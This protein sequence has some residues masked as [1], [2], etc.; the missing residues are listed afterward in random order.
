ME[1]SGQYYCVATNEFGPSEPS[2]VITINVK[3]QPGAC[4]GSVMQVGWRGNVD[5]T[6]FTTATECQD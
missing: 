2:E 1:D 5:L 6:L 3:R 4:A